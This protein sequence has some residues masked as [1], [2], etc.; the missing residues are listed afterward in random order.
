[1]PRPRRAAQVKPA[2]RWLRMLVLFA[3]AVLFLFPF[4]YMLIGSLQAEPNTG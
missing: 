4:Y 3:G 2:R 1:M